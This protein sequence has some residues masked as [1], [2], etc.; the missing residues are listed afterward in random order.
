M[1]EKKLL[2]KNYVSKEQCSYWMDSEIFSCDSCSNL[3]ECYSYANTIC[4]SEFIKDI[5]CGGYDTE[6]I[7]WE[8][9]LD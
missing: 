2:I 7:F 4:N 9:L 3:N 1:I 5:N 6:E 8:Q